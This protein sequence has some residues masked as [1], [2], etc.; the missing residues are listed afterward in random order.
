M[1]ASF[2]PKR[3][4]LLPSISKMTSFTQKAHTVV[5]DNLPRRLVNFPGGSNQLSMRSGQRTAPNYIS[6]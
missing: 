5:W 6:T 2:E 4:A 3:T 1:G